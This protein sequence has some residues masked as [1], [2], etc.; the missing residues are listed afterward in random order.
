[1][2][3]IIPLYLVFARSSGSVIAVPPPPWGDGTTVSVLDVTENPFGEGITV[4][5]N[6]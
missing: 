5:Y 2:N 4:T 6:G 3:L 1:M